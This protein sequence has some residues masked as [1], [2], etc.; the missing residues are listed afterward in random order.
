MIGTEYRRGHLLNQFL[1]V[2]IVIG[3]SLVSIVARADQTD[4]YQRLSIAISGGA[5]K[6][7]YEAGLNWAVLKLAREAENLT[8]IGGGKIRPVELAS[9]AG[10][11]AGGINSLLSG[12]T[13]C[14]RPADEGGLVSSIDD[15]LFRDAW[16]RLDINLLLP[17]KADSPVYLADDALFSRRDYF[18][19]AEELREKW[20]TPSFRPDCRVPLGVT[21]TRV[22][23]LALKV[24]EIEVHNQRFY[25]PFELRVQEDGSVAFFFDPADYPELSDPAMIL[26]PHP[27]NAAA[28]SIPDESIIEAAVTTS[29]FPTA[30]GRRRLHYCRLELD[31][32]DVLPDSEADQSDTDLICPEG[33]ILEESVFA[34]GGLFDNLPVGLARTLAELSH[35]ARESPLPVTY[36]YFDP[37]RVRYEKPAP[38]GNKACESAN[39]P[40]ACL[41]MDFSLFSESR[42][43]VG[44][45]G[46]ARKYELYRETTSEN[47]RHNLSQ[48]SYDLAQTVEQEHP[49]LDCEKELPLY[50][51]P[52]S[53]AEA[54]RR[55]GHLLNISYDRMQPEILSPYAPDRLESAGILTN[56]EQSTLETESEP[57][58]IC[59]LDFESYRNRLADALLAIIERSEIDDERLVARIDRSRHSISDDR[60]LRVSTRGTPITGTML[61]DFGSFL[62]YKFREYDYYAGVYDAVVMFSGHLC[63][64]QYSS[65]QEEANFQACAD[66][67]G[68]QLYNALGFADDAAGSYVFG[69]IAE[70]EFGESGVFEFSYLPAPAVDRDM[71]IIHDALAAGLAAGEEGGG[72]ENVL[73]AAETTFFNYLKAHD[74]SVTTTAS[75]AE[76]LLSKIIS[77]PETW[78]TE[79]TRRMTA[80]MVHLERQA[81]NI[82]ARREPDP[83]LRDSSYTVLLGATAHTLQSVTYEYPGFTFSPSTA[84]EG[85]LW[86]Y[87]IPYDFGYDFVGGD[88]NIAWQPTLAL[89]DR[90]LLNFRVSLG[91]TGGLFKSSSDKEKENFLSLGVG[92]AR[93]TGSATMS[94]YGLIPTWYHYWDQPGDNDQDTFGG[95]IF[96]GFLKDRLRLG[97]GSRNFSNFEDEWF[98]IVNFTDLPG[99]V[100]WLTR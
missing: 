38:P 95:E 32:K 98:F 58:T 77:N 29:A 42:L 43:L 91:F 15:N 70:R 74:F 82:Y 60:L 62:D 24:G 78:S 46:T 40:D 8:G 33:Y 10:A 69:R 83:E 23:P 34:D 48:L 76:P 85:W 93:R 27:R 49:D 12:L 19:T 4:I 96:V 45:L 52:V 1:A 17:P 81:A 72:Q 63:S 5:S 92:Y 90:D 55:A 61:G 66:Q 20:R 86:R 39:P 36:L 51:K 89:S 30:F 16:L 21:V 35:S 6:G 37:D 7:S 14:A 80:R 100:Y 75:G 65:R 41:V 54:I 2:M 13:W 73:F 50:D 79:M 44:A 25:I 97:L 68:E 87:V 64:L 3:F 11:S 56:C 84:P 18:A 22:E 71:Q 67:I 59:R 9:A 88:V 53:C 57:T 99:V 94:S 28:L 31:L 47:W 26:M